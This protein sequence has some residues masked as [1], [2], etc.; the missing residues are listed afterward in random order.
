MGVL[1]LAVHFQEPRSD[2]ARATTSRRSSTTGVTDM[3]RFLE[4][5]STSDDG[6]GHA[7]GGEE[8]VVFPD[9]IAFGVLAVA[10]ALGIVTKTTLAKWLP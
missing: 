3:G 7:E 4:E 2:R 8:G 6:E 1:A 9:Y 5:T 10:M